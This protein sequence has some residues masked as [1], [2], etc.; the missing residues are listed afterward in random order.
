[1]KNRFR[2]GALGAIVLA[3]SSLSSEALA[4]GA[5]VQPVVVDLQPAGQNMSRTITVQ[6]TSSRPLPVELH[7]EG[8]AFDASGPQPTGKDPG[9]LVVFPA[10]AMIAPGQTQAFRIQYAGDPQLAESQHYYVTVAQLPVEQPAAGSAIQ[11]LYNFRVMA[12]VQ[13]LGAKPSLQVVSARFEEGSDHR[14]VPVI[15]VS[16]VSNGYG[17]LSQGDL[18]IVETDAAGREVARRTLTGPEIQQSVGYGLVGPGE[19]RKVAL[20]TPAIAEGTSVDVR[21]TPQT[22][23]P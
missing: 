21:F 11:L 20:P 14:R 16:N 13:P 15:E 22:R 19:T 7:V 5:T 2:F 8:I 18:L 17:Y 1:M 9:D 4:Q 12:S 10:Q 23:R 6:N 3:L